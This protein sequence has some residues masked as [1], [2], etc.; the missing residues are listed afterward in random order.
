MLN[1]RI[2][3]LHHIHKSLQKNM[4][5]LQLENMKTKNFTYGMAKNGAKQQSEKLEKIRNFSKS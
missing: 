4:A 3:V 2:Y 5:T 1:F